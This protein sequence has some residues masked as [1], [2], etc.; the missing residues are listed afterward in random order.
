MCGGPF[1]QQRALDQHLRVGM[2]RPAEDERRCA[3]L[4]DP[5]RKHDRDPIGE[6]GDDAQVVRDQQNREAAL[7]PFAVDQPQD[8]E[9]DG[10]IQCGGRLVGDQDLRI[11]A[12]SGGDQYALRH[13][14]GE[15]EGVVPRA[16]L[17]LRDADLAEQLDDPPARVPP[18]HPEMQPQR[19]G[20]LRPRGR[21]RVEHALGLL[22]EHGGAPAPDRVQLALG[23]R[24][25]GVAAEPH[26]AVRHLEAPRQQPHQRERGQALAATGLPDEG[27]HLPGG[28]LERYVLDERPELPMAHAQVFHRQRGSRVTRGVASRGGTR[29]RG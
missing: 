12:E 6:R 15:L 28:D 16:V 5:S 10:D 25:H 4:H 8:L 14:A 22:E 29:V 3:L 23:L 17:R 20:N 19:L 11:P 1:A 27:E 9:L 13:S 18:A 26:R 7:A 24:Q 2:P 21:G